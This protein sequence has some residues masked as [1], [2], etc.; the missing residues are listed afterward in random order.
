MVVAGVAAAALGAQQRRLGH[1]FADQQHI[2][3]VDGQVPARIELPVP[4][5]GH[6]VV[7]VAQ[8]G[9][10]LDGL[11]QLV[12]LADDADQIVHGLLQVHVQRVRVLPRA[13]L[14]GRIERCHSRFRGRG[15]IGIGDLGP[16][17]QL[18]H[19]GGR[20][21]PG[22]ASEHQQIRERVAAQ[23]VGPVQTARAFAGREQAGHG[24]RLGVRIDLDATHDVVTGRADLHGFLRNV[25]IRQLLEL[26]V[27]GRQPLDDLIGGQ[28]R[29]DIQVHA[30]VR[31]PAPGLH[32]LI[33][34]AGDFVTGQQ[35]RCAPGGVV[36][37]QPLVRLFDGLG[38]LALEHRRDV[39]EHE[40]FALGVLEH[41][42]VTA[43]RLGDQDALHRRRPDHA[44]RMELQE[45]HIDQRRPGAQRQRVPVAGVLPGVRCH[46]V[47]LADATGGD[48]DRG[49]LED[50]ET[51]G[52]TPVPEGPGDPVAVL[53]QFG[54]GAFGED[55]DAR[56]VVAGLREVLLLQ[57]DDLLL[58]G[59]DELEPGA[60]ADVRQPR[61]GVAAE[62]ALAD[63]AVLGPIEQR[64]IGFQLPHPVGGLLGVQFGHAPVVEELAPAHGVL[65]M[66][67]PAVLVV[68]IAHG[69]RAAALGHDGVRLAEQG[70]ADHRH[71]QPVLTG[72]DDR[73]QTGAA[74]A[75]HEHVVLVPFDF[76]HGTEHSWETEE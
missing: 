39:A 15:Q 74:G 2:A 7:A 9:E 64:P 34:G 12:F 30:A 19:I 22:A 11:L 49:G 33:D 50:D 51:P 24:G 35:I 60:V 8:F 52:F 16:G 68:G 75:D 56:L 57:R 42:A 5:H 55:L 18:L 41:A 13:A 23:A 76:R 29:G 66:G 40:S 10:L 14:T 45:L 21:E 43:H 4:L 36:V 47:G 46:L 69:G 70:F 32:F 26:V 71:R 58:E 37:L 28:A 67:L 44:G 20:A 62:V 54:D 25:H 6:V 31:R 72:L 3:Q 61:I 38:V 27:H 65:E 1:T 48:H 63:P 59:A 53:E 73:T 17:G